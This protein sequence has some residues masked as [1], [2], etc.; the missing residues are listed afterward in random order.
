MT[1][2]ETALKDEVLEAPL[3]LAAVRECGALWIGKARFAAFLDRRF[4]ILAT[5]DKHPSSIVGIGFEREATR[6]NSCLCELG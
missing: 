3:R 5:V 4:Q 1:L 2:E 6:G